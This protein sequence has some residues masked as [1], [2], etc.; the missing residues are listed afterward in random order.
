MRTTIY[1]DGFNLYYRMLKS[2]PSLKW[3]N[4]KALAERVL[5][6]DN[7]VT[8][9]RYYTARVTGRFDASA[10]RRQEIYLDALATIPEVSVHMG[11]FLSSEKF[12]ELVHPPEFRPQIEG[13]PEPWPNVVKIL[14][15]EEKGSDVNL[16]SHL[17]L[18]AFQD[19]FD[20]AAVLSN[21][22]D[23]VEP[24]RIVTKI[25]NKKVGLLS[26]VGNPSSQLRSVAS[27]VRR[28]SRSD[29]A[30]S[31]FD[32]PLPRIGEAQLVKPQEWQ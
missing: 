20:V 18:D 1:V 23:L 11:S 24:M 7:K 14:K 26:P 32:N 5:S 2:H 21:D 22:T 3:L 29:L 12:A 30:A 17:L 8:A 10:P 6:K 31:Q 25:L 9:V 4:I 27:F 19:S 16:A 13:L 15:T 28:L